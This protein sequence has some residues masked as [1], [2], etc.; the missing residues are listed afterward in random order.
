MEILNIDVGI[1]RY[2]LVEGGAPLSFNPGD[3]NVYARYMEVVPKIK[4]V[5]QEMAGK[6]NAVDANAADA[7]KQALK[8]MRETDL[9]MKNLLNQIFGEDN[10]F[11]K[12]LKGVSLMA[13]TENGIVINNVLDVLTPIMNAG[14]KSCVDSEVKAAKMN[15]EQRRAMQ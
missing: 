3:P 15:R 9:R 12:I 4:A 10:D 2:Q 1:K 13:V 7:S 14:A 8:I 11:D 6:A 5:E